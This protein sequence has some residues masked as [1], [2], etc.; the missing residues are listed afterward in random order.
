MDL[1]VCADCG[2]TLWEVLLPLIL[3]SVV[4]VSALEAHRRGAHRLIVVLLIGIAVALLWVMADRLT[5]P[6]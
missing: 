6:W 2:P 3:G 1:Q 4:F 5:R